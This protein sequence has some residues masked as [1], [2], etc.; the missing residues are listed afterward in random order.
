[1]SIFRPMMATCPACDETF[2]MDAVESVNADRRRDLREAIIGGSFQVIG[3]PKCDARFR[4]EPLFNYL[5]VGRGQWISV[6]PLA[7]LPDWT[8]NEDEAVA[9]FSTAYGAEAPPAARDIGQ[10]LRPRLVFGWSALREKLVAAE[11]QLDDVTL[12]LLKLTL[13]GGLDKVPLAAG[14]ELRLERT[15]GDQL[16]LHWVNAQTEAIVEQLR[17]PRVLYDDIVRDAPAWAAVRESLET[18][19]FVDLQKLYLGQ[20]RPVAA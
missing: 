13:I 5:D 18:G 9:T 17:V 3:C 2:Q 7:S 10:G 12:E 8:E 14:N 19:P 11:A 1:M 4:L 6:Q 15:D 16:E 20:G